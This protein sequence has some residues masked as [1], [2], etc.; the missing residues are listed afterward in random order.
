MPNIKDQPISIDAQME[1][2]RPI[3]MAKRR[4]RV[5][6][7]QVVDR[8][9]A[10]VFDIRIGPANRLFVENNGDKTPLHCNRC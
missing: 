4:K 6:L 3:V 10:L 1:R 7:E 8:D 9:L 2:V 5:L